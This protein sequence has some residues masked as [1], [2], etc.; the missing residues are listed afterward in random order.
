[1]SPPNSMISEARNHQTP[2][3]P[4]RMPGIAC[5]EP[6]GAFYAFPNVS[7]HYGKRSRDREIRS[8]LDFGEALLEHAHLAVVPGGPFG[9]DRHVRLSYAASIEALSRALDRLERFIKELR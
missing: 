5:A 7:A 3:F 6:W 8:S 4:G 1:M 9:S 2:T